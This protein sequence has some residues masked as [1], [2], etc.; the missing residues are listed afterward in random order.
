MFSIINVEVL[1]IMITVKTSNRLVFKGG[2]YMNALYVIGNINMETVKI[3]AESIQKVVKRKN[4]FDKLFII[5]TDN[6]HNSIHEQEEIYFDILGKMRSE[7]VVLNIYDPEEQKK[8]VAIFK[9]S[10]DRFIDLTNGLKPIAAILYMVANLCGINNLYYLM[11]GSD[12]SSQYIRMNRFIETDAFT[13]FAFYDLVYYNEEIDT[14][15]LNVK[16]N[17][18]EYIN[19]CY[20]ELKNAVTLFFIQKDYKNTILSATCGVEGIVTN[21]LDYLKSNHDI[22]KFADAAG[23]QLDDEKKDPIGIETYFFKRFFNQDNCIDRKKI[24]SISYLNDLHDV[25]WILSMLR[26]FRNAAAH[27]SMHSHFFK[28]SEARLAL[29]ASIELYRTLKNNNDLWNLLYGE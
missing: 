17:S 6:L 28:E 2:E 26:E 13:E 21:L 7:E 14:V 11:R 29:N 12:G 16:S 4:A 24:N 9:E 22:K 10:D 5:S 20:N 18:N 8:L 1:S 23:I 19:K 3:V 27:Y 25:P 15:F